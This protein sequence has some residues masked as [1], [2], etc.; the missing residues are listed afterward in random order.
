MVPRGTSPP[1]DVNLLIRRLEEAHPDA[2]CA[3]THTNPF[4]LLVATILSAQCTDARVNQ[5]T[6]VLF[7]RFPD[8]EAMSLA[9][10]EELE[11]L[12]RTTGFFRNKSKSIRGSSQRL[13]EAFGGIVPRSMDEL[14]SLPGVARKTAN[15]VLGVGHGIA[16]GVVVDT[17]VYRVSRRL[18]LTRGKG[19]VEVEQDL[20]QTIP[21]DK[22]IEFAH[23]LIFHGRRV[24]VARKP[25]CEAC[26]VL[27][28]CPSASYFLAGKVPPWDRGGEAGEPRAAKKGPRSRVAAKVAAGGKATARKRAVPKPAASRKARKSSAP[29]KL[30]KSAAARAR[31]RAS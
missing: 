28:L 2:A 14:L 8:A 15:V 7:A 25:R 20:M 9:S 4:Q 3:L 1:A 10:Q 12:I 18:G 13:V 21:R 19:P 16:E 5:V 11:A 23:L 6:P 29:R 24:C 27:D 17:H 31:R 22:W 26:A 30:R